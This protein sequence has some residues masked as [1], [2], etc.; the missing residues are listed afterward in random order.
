MS[1][2]EGIGVG[3][4]RKWQRA[5][6]AKTRGGNN[7]VYL[8]HGDKWVCRVSSPRDWVVRGRQGLDLEGSR[9]PTGSLRAV[10]PMSHF[11]TKRGMARLAAEK[12]PDGCDGGGTGVG[13]T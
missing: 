2:A 12:A 10:G 11:I 7:P 4:E 9:D 3:E 5:A 8:R 1:K 6:P 13:D